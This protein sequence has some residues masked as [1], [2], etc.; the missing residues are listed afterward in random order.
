LK[1][2]GRGE[3]IGVVIHTCVE[4][5]QGN[6]LCSYLYLKVANRLV[7]CFI[8]YVFSSAK[9]EYR[10]TEPSAWGRESMVGTGGR[11]EVAG[12]GEGG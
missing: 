10:S 6:S 8:F 12:K 1:R 3:S 2:T 5:I 4:T 9:S 11:E 7:S